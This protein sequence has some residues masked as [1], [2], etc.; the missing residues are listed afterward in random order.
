MASYAFVVPVL[1][2]MEERNRQF[3][4][5]LQGARK[6][7]FQ[8]SRERA[9][10]TVERVWMQ[11][12]PAGT[13]SVVYLEADDIGRALGTLATSQDPFDA[14]WR[15]HILEIHGIDLSQP[16]PGPMNDLILDYAR[17]ENP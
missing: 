8:A 5:E 3:S 9:G 7:E 11:Q 17:A 2:G 16:L 13:M 12:T 10:L 14:R 4:A 1:P 6:A 15:Q